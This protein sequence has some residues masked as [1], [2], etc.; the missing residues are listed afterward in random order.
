MVSMVLVIFESLKKKK[1]I[2][3]I[4]RILKKVYETILTI[5]NSIKCVKKTL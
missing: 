4:K 1:K 5:R 3:F 2:L